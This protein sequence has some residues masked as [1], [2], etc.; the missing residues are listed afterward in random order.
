M[1]YKWYTVTIC[2]VYSGAIRKVHACALTKNEALKKVE[3]CAKL[4]EYEIVTDARQS[5]DSFYK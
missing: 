2:N 4:E 5:K 1:S 3:K